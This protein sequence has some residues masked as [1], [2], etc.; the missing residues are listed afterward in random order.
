MMKINK[1]TIL[2]AF[3]ALVLASCRKDHYDVSNV[4]GVNAEGEMLLPIGSDSFTMMDMMKRFKIDSIISCAD[5]GSLSFDYFY[6]DYGVING[7]ELLRFKDLEY[8]AHFEMANPYI[9]NLPDFDDTVVSLRHTI[10][11]EAEHV[12]VFEAKMKSGQLDFDVASNLGILQH[13]V[14]STPDIKDASGNDFV[15]EFYPQSDSFGFNLAGLH[16]LTDSPNTLTINCEIR[17]AYVHTIA[18]EL[19]VDLKIEGT[20]LAFSEMKG[21]V[22][23]YDSRNSIDTTFSLFPGNLSGMLEVDDVT[24]RLSERNTFGLGARLVVDTAMVMSDGI[25][26]Y[27]VIEPLPLVVELPEQLEFTEVYSRKV[28]GRITPTGG[29]A[30]ASSVFTVNP[31]GEEEM[32]T[33]ADTCNLDVRVDVSLPFSF[34]TSEVQYLDTVDLDLSELRLPEFVKTLTLEL[35]FVSTLPLNLEG[36]F[37]MYDSENEIVTDTLI[38]EGKLI[39]ASFDGYPKSTTIS[40]DVTEERIEKVLHSDRIIMQYALDTD[41]RNVKITAD[42]KLGVFVKAK[43]SYDGVVEF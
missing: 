40:I 27:S 20:D 18:S 14:L 1:I 17:C 33:I 31:T 2:L 10:E 12:K 23:S 3:L 4:H 26:P 38:G 42:Q 6:E 39:E 43:A 25:E 21:F 34:N 16:Y 41:A 7:G 35:T 13:V 28:D 5:D 24:L 37:F 36:Q 30:V 15:M 11:F 8:D 19:F 32:V 29:R 22:E 9:G